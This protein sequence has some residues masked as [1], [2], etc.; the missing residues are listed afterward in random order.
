MSGHHVSGRQ[1]LICGNP[2]SLARSQNARNGVS[3]TFNQ[4]GRAALAAFFRTQNRKGIGAGMKHGFV[5]V[6]AATPKI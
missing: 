2:P 3:G 1:R 4:R 6:A 5:K